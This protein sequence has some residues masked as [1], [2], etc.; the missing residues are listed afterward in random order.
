MNVLGAVLTQNAT[1]S[2]PPIGPS[3]GT[4]MDFDTESF[5]GCTFESNGKTFVGRDSMDFYGNDLSL[6]S[7]ADLTTCVQ[8]CAS[9]VNC[10]AV[11]W[12]SGNCYLKSAVGNAVFNTWVDGMFNTRLLMLG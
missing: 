8:L 4:V 9:T 5:D 10:K 2:E 6:A 12:T 11:S 7:T 3:C 1:T